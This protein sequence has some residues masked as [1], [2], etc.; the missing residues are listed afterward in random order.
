MQHLTR[1]VRPGAGRPTREQAEQR[2][3]ELLDRALEQ[4]LEKGFELATMEAIAA[5]VG[6]TKRTVYARYED[7]RALFKAAVQRAV[8]GWTVPVSALKAAESDDLEASLVAFARIRMANAISPV[9]LR[10]QRIINTE[11]YRFPEIFTHA[12]DQGSRP[13]LEYLADFLRRRM[14]AGDVCVD[15]PETAATAFLSMVVG[16]PIRG[17]VLGGPVDAAALEA[18]IKFCVKLFLNGV[19]PR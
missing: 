11:S 8:D 12:H 16:G 19:R 3:E 17:I 7:K 1:K 15:D 9:G 5:S 13:T 18:R 4:F 14:K 6:M 2:H 10:L